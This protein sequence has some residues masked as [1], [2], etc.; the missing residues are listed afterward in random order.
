MANLPISGLP[1]ASALDGTELLPFVQGGVTTQATVQDILDADLPLTS[2]GITLSGDIVPATPQGANLGSLSQPFR[3]IFLQSGSLNIESDTPGDPNTVVS[4]TN[5]NLLVSA[6]G[7]QLLGS[8]SFNAA[9]G[10]FQYQTG[11]LVY[12]GEELFLG[13]FEVSGAFT[14][15]LTEDN[16]W[17]G[18]SN[19]KSIEVPISSLPGYFPF[20]YGLFSQTAD[21]TPITGTDVESSLINGGVGTLSVPAN[22]FQVG[23]SFRAVTSGLMTVANGQ[24]L[25]LKVKAGSLILLDS[26]VQTII[27]NITDD[28]F[29]L[30]IDFTIR[31]IGAAG[32]ASIA[33]LG[34]FHYTKTNNGTVEGFSFYAVN[35]TTFD[36]TISNTLDITAQ[37]GSTN[38]GNSIYSDI[39]ILN[40]TY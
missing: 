29:T 37:W 22:G 30:N 13:S 7:M 34:A 17:I 5:G 40:K 2:S 27:N 15:S 6:G 14:A 35:N 9:T 4:N 26:G 32:V 3:E 38:V 11:S 25:R 31:Q 20:N 28:V 19:N 33:S 16:I 18:D 8:G 24:T 12:E 39:F 10:S 1:T 36:T 23:D 21:S